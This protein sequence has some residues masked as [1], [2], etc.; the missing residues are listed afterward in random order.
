[1]SN[2]QDNDNLDPEE[3]TRLFDSSEIQ[4][5]A[6]QTGA[7][8]TEVRQGLAELFP[9]VV[10]ATPEGGLEHEAQANQEVD[11]IMVVIRYAGGRG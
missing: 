6:Q 7:D 9:E 8:E 11:A 10:T 4:Q 2:Q 1:M 5:V 3:V